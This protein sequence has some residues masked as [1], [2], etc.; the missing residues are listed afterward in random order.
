MSRSP[1]FKPVQTTILAL[2]VA[3]L[4]LMLV[5]G[6][7]WQ[8]AV[9]TMALLFILWTLYL[10][11]AYIAEE[12]RHQHKWGIFS[13]NL[14]LGWTIVGWIAMLVWALTG[15]NSARLATTPMPERRSA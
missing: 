2:A 9:W 3:Y 1:R 10:L 14:V 8:E 12:R 15:S 13:L 5:Q 11:P 7:G 4:A 6:M